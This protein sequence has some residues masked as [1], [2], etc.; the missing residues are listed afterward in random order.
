MT[1]EVQPVCA[2]CDH[3][4]IE[5]DATGPCHQR[6]AAGVDCHCQEWTPAAEAQPGSAPDDVTRLTLMIA[7]CW[8][9]SANEMARRLLAQGVT[10]PDPPPDPAVVVAEA[11]ADIIW[12][13]DKWQVSGPA[14][15]RLL[16]ALRDT[17]TPEALAETAAA[18]DA[19]R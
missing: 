10:L 15:R 4:E 5:H 1:G 18:L 17:F 19:D 3:T 13:V 14:P 16:D 12:G 2:G 8:H 11:L 6:S 9:M 7:R